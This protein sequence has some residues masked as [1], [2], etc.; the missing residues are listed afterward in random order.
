LNAY[1]PRILFIFTAILYASIAYG[2]QETIIKGRITEKGKPESLPFV[3][4]YMKGTQKGT[5]SDFEGNFTL[6]VNTNVD[7]IVFSY[8]GYKT[9]TRKIVVGQTQ[10]LRVEM[11]PDNTMIQDVIIIAGENPALRIIKKAAENKAK[12][13]QNSLICFDYDSYTKIDISMNNI[14]EKMKNNKLFKPLKSLFDTANQIK[15]DEGK[16]ILPIFVSETYSHFYQNNAPPLTK[17]IIK[18]SDIKFEY[19]GV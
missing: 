18:A 17:E 15:N 16:Y 12:N 10:T 11:E 5:S 14:T 9:V 7:S 1:I 8:V 2:Q 3:S 6:K 13:N 4:I 19:F